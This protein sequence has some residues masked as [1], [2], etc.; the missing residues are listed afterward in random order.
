MHSY[1]KTGRNQG[2]KSRKVLLKTKPDWNP[3]LPASLPYLFKL[4]ENSTTGCGKS[5]GIYGNQ[6]KMLYP[7]VTL[8][9]TGPVVIRT[10]Q[11]P[12]L[13]ISKKYFN[14]ILPPTHLF[15]FIYLVPQCPI[16]FRPNY[17][18][19]HREATST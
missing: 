3:V 9:E 12:L 6:Q 5:I 17:G 16:E 13:I 10:E 7:C 2:W 1:N 4:R 14:R 8:P 19:M 15:F 11:E 18:A